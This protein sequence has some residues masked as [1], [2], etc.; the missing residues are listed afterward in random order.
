MKELVLPPIIDR[1]EEWDELERRIKQAFKEL[2]YQPLL[3]LLPLQPKLKNSL[4]QLESVIES[5][6]IIF[7]RGSFKGKFSATTSREL[8]RLGAKWK[9]GKW[10]IH[11]SQL[12]QTTQDAIR[13]SEAALE[14]SLNKIDRQLLETIPESVAESVKASDLFER[15]IWRTNKDFKET[16]KSLTISPKLTESQVSKIASEYTL[17]LQKYIKDW[18]ESE[19]RTLRE[20]IKER[21]L[22]GLRY[23]GM[24]S[25]I[26]ARYGVSE[27]KAT[28]LARQETRLMMTKF[29]ESRYTDAG[30][31]KYKWVCAAGSPKHPVRPMHKRLNGKIF[32]WDNPPITADNGA[33]NNPGQDYNCRCTARAIVTF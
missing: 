9:D 27:R 21:A 18:T 4:N 17:D 2:I 19:I 11:L 32:T 29:K 1:P 31:N 7:E 33:R 16:V 28:F 24:V 12:P 26:K 22:K 3:R 8:K 20:K 6:R 25:E 5:G 14:Q 13:R 23:E 10:N 15:S 30:I